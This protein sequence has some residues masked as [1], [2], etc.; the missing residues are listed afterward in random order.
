MIAG[1][2]EGAIHL[3]YENHIVIKNGTVNYSDTTLFTMDNFTLTSSTG[4]GT[5]GS[6]SGAVVV[7]NTQR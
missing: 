4:M 3:E 6:Y 2:T 5:S 1:P 7:A